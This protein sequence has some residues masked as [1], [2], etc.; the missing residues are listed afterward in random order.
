MTRIFRGKIPVLLKQK[1]VARRKRKKQSLNSIGFRF[2]LYRA[3]LGLKAQAMAERINI[4]QGSYSDI[5]ADNSEPS[6]Q[7]II[8]IFKLADD[9]VD[10]CWLLTGYEL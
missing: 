6:C 9:P 8:K 2:E 4:S 1:L 5:Q 10:V 3:H 7:T